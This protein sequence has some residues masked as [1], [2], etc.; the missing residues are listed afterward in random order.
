MGFGK[1]FEAPSL[2][3][4]SLE[5]LAVLVASMLYCGSEEQEHRSSIRIVPTITDN[6]GNGS[7]LNKLMSTKYPASAAIVE[8]ASF[9]EKIGR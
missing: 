7:V 4:S 8:L 2:V 9:M 3:I 5:A 1:E 6:R